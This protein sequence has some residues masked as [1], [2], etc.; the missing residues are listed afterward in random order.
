MMGLYRV[1]FTDTPC[2][3]DGRRRRH[4][5]R[6]VR[7]LGTA[8]SPG[9]SV[10]LAVVAACKITCNGRDK[11]IRGRIGVRSLFGWGEH[12][13]LLATGLAFPDF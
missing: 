12:E 1:G 4:L 8:L 5:H 11:V 9:R 3:V 2:A 13:I 10:R 7:S 6:H